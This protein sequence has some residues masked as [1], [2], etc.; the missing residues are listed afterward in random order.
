MQPE[1]VRHHTKGWFYGVI[2]CMRSQ[3]QGSK[4][5]DFTE[6][7][8]QHDHYSQT[9]I[10]GTV[11]LRRCSHSDSW[12]HQEFGLIRAILMNENNPRP[13]VAEPMNN[14]DLKFNRLTGERDIV[15]VGR[16]FYASN[17]LYLKR[18]NR[19]IRYFLRM[20]MIS[21]LFKS[22]SKFECVGEASVKFAIIFCLW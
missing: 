13:A 19:E 9:L 14:C 2:F 3:V 12:L 5:S 20:H 17:A 15:Q 8:R 6:N 7:L 10:R 1:P 22:R 21:W 18:H 16:R 4:G 11:T